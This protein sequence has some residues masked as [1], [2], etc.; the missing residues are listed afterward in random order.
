MTPASWSLKLRKPWK[1]FNLRDP[2]ICSSF[3]MNLRI[4]RSER[5]IWMTG[6]PIMRLVMCF[7]SRAPASPMSFSYVTTLSN[8]LILSQKWSMRRGG[9]SRKRSPLKENALWLKASIRRGFWKMLNSLRWRSMLR[10]WA[11]LISQWS[12]LG[13]WRAIMW[14]LWPVQ[15]LMIMEIYRIASFCWIQQWI[16]MLVSSVKLYLPF[17]SSASQKVWNDRSVKILRRNIESYIYIQH[18]NS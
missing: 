11:N 8:S 17:V 15:W 5:S 14:L 6:L 3:H 4:K 7:K 13:I 16:I 1:W 12:L 9:G 18:K 2:L 10:N